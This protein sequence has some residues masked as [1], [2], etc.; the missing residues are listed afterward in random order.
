M[1]TNTLYHKLILAAR[2]AP[3]PDDVPYAFEKRVMA[4]LAGRPPVDAWALW[5]RNLWRSAALCGFVCLAVGGW[6]YATVSRDFSSE[7]MSLAFEKTV[8]APMDQSL[9]EM[10]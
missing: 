1:D 6:R 3:S 7:A 4:R 9:G 8:F 10:W 5:S 2:K